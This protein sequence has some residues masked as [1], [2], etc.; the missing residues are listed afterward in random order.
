MQ[1][2]LQNMYQIRK[3]LYER[4]ADYRVSNT[5][6]PEETAAQILQLEEDL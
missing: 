3:P 4:F 6:S 2:D 5:G 1:S